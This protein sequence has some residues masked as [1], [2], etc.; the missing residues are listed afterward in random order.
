MLTDL[1]CLLAALVIT[2][3]A[4]YAVL[5]LVYRRGRQVDFRIGRGS[6]TGRCSARAA[7]SCA[8]APCTRALSTRVALTTCAGAEIVKGDAQQRCGRRV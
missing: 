4:M 8:C 1:A 7:S 2:L 5:Q 6:A 3:L